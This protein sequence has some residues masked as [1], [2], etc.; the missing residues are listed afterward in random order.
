MTTNDIIHLFQEL[1]A[2]GKD[3]HILRHYSS[4]IVVS[5]GRVIYV[6]DPTMISCPLANVLYPD[7]KDMIGD[8]PERQKKLIKDVVETK[9]RKTGQFTDRRKIIDPAIA[10]PYGASEMILTALQKNVVDAA[11]IVCDGAGTIVA[12]NPD[13]VQGVGGRMNGLFF[14]SPIRS[15]QNSLDQY[16]CRRVSPTAAINQAAGV[17]KAVQQGYRRIAVT[18]NAFGDES[19]NQIRVI[20]KKNGVIVY[21]FIVCTTGVGSARIAEIGDHADMVW[22]C[23]SMDLRR[24]IGGRAILQFSKAIPVFVLTDQGMAIAKAYVETPAVLDKASKTHPL[25][26]ADDCPG[27]KIRVGNF[28]ARICQTGLPVQG[29]RQP[30]FIRE[31]GSCN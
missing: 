10:V 21:I 22:S 31:E 3:V 20:E 2:S 12:D 4:L 16:G 5:E 25:L 19:L 27:E 28:F 11:V 18:I 8:D 9:I 6:T 23:G 7:L 15:I 1:I 13:V 29:K 24:E 14:T 26:I 17:E 30:A